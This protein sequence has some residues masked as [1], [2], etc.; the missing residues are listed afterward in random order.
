MMLRGPLLSSGVE[1]EELVNWI[2]ATSASAR[3]TVHEVGALSDPP[4]G[5]WSRSRT[6]S[7]APST[8]RSASAVSDTVCVSPSIDP[9]GNV[10]A[11]VAKVA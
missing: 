9:A 8:T 11:C 5:C 1:L 4:S 10:T 6:V 7:V 2:D 3:E